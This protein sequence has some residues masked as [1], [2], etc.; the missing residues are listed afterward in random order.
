[1]QRDAAR[2]FF[3]AIRA[4]GRSRT[5][6]SCRRPPESPCGRHTDIFLLC[7]AIVGDGSLTTG[8]RRGQIRAVRTDFKTLNREQL[9]RK[10]IGH[11][12]ESAFTSEAL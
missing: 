6:Q 11:L 4:R 9:S 7:G 10:R 1:M 12:L 3:G 8:G 5:A 2:Q